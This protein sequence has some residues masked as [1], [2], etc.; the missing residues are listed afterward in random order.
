MTPE[1]HSS[2]RPTPQVVEE[3]HVLGE[4]WSEFCVTT[5]TP[6]DEVESRTLVRATKDRV[7]FLDL[8]IE[9]YVGIS[10]RA[11]L[12]SVRLEEDAMRRLYEVLAVK[13]D[14]HPRAR[15]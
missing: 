14:A 15:G 8:S 10:R 1:S 2:R 11:K 6:G 7:A 3:I 4:H 9:E 5:R 12:T 13:F